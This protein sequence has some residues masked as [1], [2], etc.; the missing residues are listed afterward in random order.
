MHIDPQSHSPFFTLPAELRQR[1]YTLYLDSSH[2]YR[3]HARAYF[4]APTGWLHANLGSLRRLPVHGHP[5]FL[6]TCKRAYLDLYHEA[7]HQAT[8]VIRHRWRRNEWA[9][10]YFGKPDP[11]R[12]TKL[13]VIND[14]S[15]GNSVAVS[16]W[17]LAILLP[18]LARELLP[19]R[20]TG[21]VPQ[22]ELP[23]WTPRSVDELN[24]RELVV[25]KW[26]GGYWDP[27]SWKHPINP[28]SEGNIAEDQRFWS[29]CCG[30]SRWR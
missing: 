8:F 26:P 16:Y 4:T 10:G 3:P 27:G 2:R 6:L 23:T 11:R 5:S 20:W 1:I 30:L 14:L 22:I 9:L 17:G 19:D 29:S 21:L 18:L 12:W 7:F 24:L 25:D 13:V 28:D 15:S